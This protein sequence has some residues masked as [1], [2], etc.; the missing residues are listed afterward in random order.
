MSLPAVLAALVA[1]DL[2]FNLALLCA[3]LRAG[4]HSYRPSLQLDGD[5]TAVVARL[6]RA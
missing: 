4:Q 1:A 6:S 5:R 3:R 2:A